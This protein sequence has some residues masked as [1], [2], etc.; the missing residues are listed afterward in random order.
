MSIAVEVTD[1][2]GVERKHSAGGITFFKT[3]FVGLSKTIP[4]LHLLTAKADIYI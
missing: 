1:S 2:K 4:A 3:F